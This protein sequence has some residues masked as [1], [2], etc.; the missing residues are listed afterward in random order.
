[1][2][3]RIRNTSMICR[4]LIFLLLPLNLFAQSDKFLIIKHREKAKEVVISEGAFVSVKT[5]KG[6]RIRGIMLVLTEDLIKVKHKVVP[7]TNVERIGVRNALML[8]IGS[9]S[10]SMGM[11]LVLFGVQ[12]NLKNGWQKAD[13]N[14]GIGLP[15]LSAGLSMVWITRKRRAKHWS[16]HGQMPGW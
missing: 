15:F 9:A 12:R 13:E 7:L 4:M 14:Y 2:A 10:I 1:M 6:E 11:N 3:W 5:F 8:Q 16:F